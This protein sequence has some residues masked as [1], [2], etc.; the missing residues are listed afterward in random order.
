[1]TT[2]VFENLS[3]SVRTPQ[4]SCLSALFR[5]AAACWTGLGLYRF[6]SRCANLPSCPTQA[7]QSEKL[8]EAKKKLAAKVWLT[9]GVGVHSGERTLH[10]NALLHV[11]S[12]R[13]QL[14]P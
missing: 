7:A 14:S 2:D 9:H 12:V 8:A 1:M 13:F 4:V 5:L 10:A 11:A 3:L 6:R